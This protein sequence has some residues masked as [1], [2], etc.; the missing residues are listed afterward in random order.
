MKRVVSFVTRRAATFL[1][2]AVFALAA[3][4]PAL[5]QISAP[6]ISQVSISPALS[7]PHQSAGLAGSSAMAP[8]DS[9]TPRS[10]PS[11][12]PA[13]PS[14]PPSSSSS[15]NAS[16]PQP[17]SITPSSSGVTITIPGADPESGPGP[18]GPNLGAYET[19]GVGQQPSG[20]PPGQVDSPG[21]TASVAGKLDTSDLTSLPPSGFVSANKVGS[22]GQAAADVNESEVIVH[23]GTQ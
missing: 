7:G 20:A 14:A 17:P 1:T 18:E 12:L 15:S 10:A 23:G 22:G 13:L 16:S 21:V 8:S 3:S 19:V 2:A 11:G 9:S 5:A 6:A 4:S